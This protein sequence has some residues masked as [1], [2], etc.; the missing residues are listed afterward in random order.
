MHA[1]DHRAELAEHCAYQAVQTVFG[2]LSI[3]QMR[4]PLRKHKDAQ[5]ARQIA[6]RIMAEEL[7]VD[8]RQVSRMQKRQRTNI[9][10]A[11]QTVNER[12][13]DSVFRAAYERMAADAR[14]AYARAMREAA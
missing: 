6:I 11:L 13:E 7:A 2:W 12:L 1:S 4:K 14:T 3:E 5:L 10:F 8:Q 9:H